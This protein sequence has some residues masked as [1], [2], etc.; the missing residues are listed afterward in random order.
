MALA[1][2][3][4]SWMFAATICLVGNIPA[5]GCPNCKEAVSLQPEDAARMSSGY[6]WS[7]MFMLAVPASMFSTGAMMVHRAAKKG[8]FPEF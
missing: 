5:I 8:L 3:L 2:R 7:V 6:N 1:P 4:R